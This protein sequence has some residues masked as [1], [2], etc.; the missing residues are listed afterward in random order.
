MTEPSYDQCLVEAELRARAAYSEPHRHYHDERH[1]KDCLAELDRVQG[2]S[3][4][5]VRLLKWAILWHDSIY[6]PG[7][8]NNELKSA[9]LARFEL[10]RC[11]V[12]DDE[13][14]EVERLVLA[15]RSHRA[16]P[17]DQLGRLMVSI[18]LAILGSD[19]DR[20]ASYVA[21]VRHEYAHV[22]DPLWR[23]GRS[24][25]LKRLLDSD[26]IYPDPD[27]RARLEPQARENIQ[28]EI[29]ALGEG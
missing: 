21:A 24:L 13:A 8:R 5:E 12:P 11:G 7:Q 26:S 3:A 23:T 10:V 20:Y 29:T 18:D 27:F 2:L 6:E 17:G 16:D 4:R 14:Q 15:T 1:L 28:A 19:P 22:Q 25:V 9:E